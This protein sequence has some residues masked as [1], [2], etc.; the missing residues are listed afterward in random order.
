[1]RPLRIGTRGSELALWQANQVAHKLGANG[2]PTEICKVRTTGDK[3]TDVSLATIGGK[4]LFIKE[5]EE[6]LAAD[7]VDLAVHSL[8]D[9]PSII[10][11][12]F[13]LVAFLERADP[14]DAWI[15]PAAT[16]FS[17]L[18]QGAR[19]GT[20]AP[21]RAAQLRILRPDIEIV[22]IRGN[23]DTRVRKASEG[24]CD[25]VV[26]A[27]AGLMRLGRGEVI[28]SRFSLGEMTP[29]AGQGI[30]GIEVLRDRTDVIEAVQT[31][32][33]LRAALAARVER[34]VLQQ[35][36]TVLDCYSSIAVHAELAP[37]T[38]RCHAFLSDPQGARQIR[39][40][41]EA[42][43]TRQEALIESVHKNLCD[44]GAMQILQTE[45]AR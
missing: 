37:V 39:I 6:A 30:V 4:G 3:R 1:M 19:V 34:G 21:R 8:K 17:Q 5:L 32:N 7:Q 36:G 9:V 16:E 35:F 11:E 29:A 43:S 12:Q 20:S 13:A 38:I 31:I 45:Y 26:L 18:P 41:E 25:G 15:H 10:P 22:E 28:T 42:D 24:T 44:Q 40:V 27:T 14:R 23:V 2:F 33:D